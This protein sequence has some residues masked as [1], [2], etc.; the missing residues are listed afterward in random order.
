MFAGCVAGL[1]MTLAAAPGAFA[2]E[3][4]SAPL[5]KELVTALDASKLDSIAA[6]D[7]SAADV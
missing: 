3:S 4:K 6:K 1:C 7:P 2:Q 5:A